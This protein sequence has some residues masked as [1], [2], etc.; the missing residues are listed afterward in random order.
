MKNTI[1]KLEQW[2]YLL[3]SQKE[4]P[5]LSILWWVHGDETCWVEVLNILRKKLQITQWQVFLMYWNLEAIK[6]E[7]RQTDYNLNRMFQNENN[8]SKV[9]K[10]SYEYTRAQVIKKYLSESDAGLDLHS[11]PSKGSPAFIICEDNAQEI[12]KNFPFKNICSWFDNVEP[13]WTDFYMNSIWKIWI[14]VECGNHNDSLA[15]QNAMNSVIKFLIFYNII[16]DKNLLQ[17]ELNIDEKNINKQ[18]F[19]ATRAYITQTN[20]FIIPRDF[21]DFEKVSKWELIWKDWE[22]EILSDGDSYL[23]F[24]RSRNQKWVEAFIELTKTFWKK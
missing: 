19:N 5:T 17:V 15:S 22:E 4:W 11:S 13:G 23:L 6:K 18:Y 8:Y 7:K 14:C 2:I 20:N 24:A 21:S 12:I 3:D 16:D 1:S 9:E 10:E